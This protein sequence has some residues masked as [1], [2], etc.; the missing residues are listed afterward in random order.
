MSPV[1]SYRVVL[2]S[3]NWPRANSNLVPSGLGRRP[4]LMLVSFSFLFILF[5]L[6]SFLPFFQS[7][8]GVRIYHGHLPGHWYY[9]VAT[10]RD[11]GIPQLV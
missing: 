8:S 5:C 11:D 1:W 3:I 2:W 6:F 10:I 4:E 9:F 7:I